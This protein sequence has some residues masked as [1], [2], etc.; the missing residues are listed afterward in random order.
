M[1]TE[2]ATGE[3]CKRRVTAAAL[4]QESL[5]ICQHFKYCCRLNRLA[6]PSFLSLWITALD[7]PVTK[8]ARVSQV[9]PSKYPHTARPQ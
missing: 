7:E 8:C 9:V 2:E 5:N 3:G 6:F 1:A 4:S